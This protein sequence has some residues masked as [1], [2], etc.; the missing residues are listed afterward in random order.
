MSPVLLLS[1]LPPS[2][3]T[4]AVAAAA[5]AAPALASP[6]PQLPATQ[7]VLTHMHTHDKLTSHATVQ[8]KTIRQCHAA[9]SSGGATRLLGVMH[10]LLAARSRLHGLCTGSAQGYHFVP[11]RYLVTRP[12][13]APYLLGETSSTRCYLPGPARGDGRMHQC[14]RRINSRNS[15]GSMLTEPVAQHCEFLRSATKPYRK[16]RT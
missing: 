4:A 5:P 11:Y 6:S 7:H 9:S 10:S 16:P 13:F 12:P 1:V 15:V 14:V 2:A 3:A 8:P